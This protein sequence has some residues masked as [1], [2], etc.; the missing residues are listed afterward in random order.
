M[1]FAGADIED[2][3]PR[4]RYLGEAKR[5]LGGLE[6]QLSDGREWVTGK[7]T[8]A[9]IAIAPWLGALDYYEAK[10]MVGWDKHPNIVNYVER[11]MARPAVQIG[12]NVPPRES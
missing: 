4:E 2:P 1:K 11:F 9:D 3:R 12:R 6:T 8:I 10:E 7:F 5:L